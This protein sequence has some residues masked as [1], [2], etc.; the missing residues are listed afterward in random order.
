MPQYPQYSPQPQ[1]QTRTPT[2][3]QMQQ[4]GYARPPQPQTSMQPQQSMPGVQVQQ[5]QKTQQMQP[6]QPSQTAQQMTNMLGVQQPQMQP[7]IPQ[8]TPQQP[9]GAQAPMPAGMAGGGVPAAP[10]GGGATPLN[11]QLQTQAGN[12][13]SNPNPYTSDT[14]MQVFNALNTKLGQQYDLAR[15]GL[16]AQDASRGM[17]FSTPDNQRQQLLSGYQAQAQQQLASDIA[18]KAAMTDAYARQA[19]MGSG[20]GVLS[21]QDQLLLSMLGLTGG[22]VMQ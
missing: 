19:A 6:Q 15:Q 1:Q 20:L 8:Y 3:G 18:E 14:A 12:W 13:I 9:T 2:F 4:Q 17:F 21:E 16:T 5:P 22:G 7:N 10:G 11:Q